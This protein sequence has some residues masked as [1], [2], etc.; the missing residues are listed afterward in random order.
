MATFFSIDPSIRACG[1]AL[2]INSTIIAGLFRSKKQ[3]TH[4]AIIEIYKNLRIICPPDVDH[5]IIEK[6]IIKDAWTQDK[7]ENIA[8][9][10]ACYGMCLALAT[11]NT[12]MWTP[13]V[14]EWKGQLSKENSHSRAEELLKKEKIIIDYVGKIPDS[15]LHN[16]KDAIALLVKYLVKERII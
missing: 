10:M 11:N 8:K 4:R 7:K 12:K 6:P 9:L 16:T 1:Y 5:L 2:L 14:P 15:L 3:E 13:S